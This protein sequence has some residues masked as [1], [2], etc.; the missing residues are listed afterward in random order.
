MSIKLKKS[1]LA[2]LTFIFCSSL[3]AEETRQHGTHEHGVAQLRI[4][5]EG[6]ELQI[7]LDSPSFNLL[8]FAVP[9]SEEQHALVEALEAKLHKPIELFQISNADC[10]AEKTHLHSPVF[11][12][13]AEGEEHAEDHHDEHKDEHKDE[14]HDDEHHDEE[15]HDEEHHDEHND[16][17]SHSDILVQWQFHCESLE[18]LSQLSVTLFDHFEHLE[19]LQVQYLLGN[20]QGSIDLSATQNAVSF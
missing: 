17:E 18:G 15:H 8:G 2:L 3:Y 1:P 20:E 10:V 7:E 5:G 12:G 6:S 13:H 4:A 19:E 14:H 16:E 11:T 9:E